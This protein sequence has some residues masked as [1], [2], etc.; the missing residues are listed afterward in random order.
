MYFSLIFDFRFINCISYISL[1]LYY[2]WVAVATFLFQD[3]DVPGKSFVALKIFLKFPLTKGIFCFAKN[4][5][6]Y[7]Y[8]LFFPYTIL[9][10][11]KFFLLFDD[12][13]HVRTES[14]QH[15]DCE[16]E[17]IFVESAHS[18][19][20]LIRKIHSDDSLR[21]SY[22]VRLHRFDQMF[23]RGKDPGVVGQTSFIK[24]H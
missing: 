7:V 12:D 9:R 10:N 23:V 8:R 15:F 3:L 2:S 13:F 4:S 1:S 24:Y 14:H 5:W 17:L 19:L 6:M 21:K 18:L 11:R 22:E 16:E 20:F